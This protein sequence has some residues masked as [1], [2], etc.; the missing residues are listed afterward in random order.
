VNGENLF[1][2]DWRG[3]FIGVEGFTSDTSTPL[4]GCSPPSLLDHDP[5]HGFANGSKEV[6]AAVPVL[7]FALTDEPEISLMN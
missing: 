7:N 3:D 2:G 6:P 4:G 1:I 5:A